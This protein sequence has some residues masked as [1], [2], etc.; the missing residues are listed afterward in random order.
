MIVEEEKEIDAEGWRF[1]GTGCPYSRWRFVL[2]SPLRNIHEYRTKL[3]SQDLQRRWKSVFPS[4]SPAKN[5]K[6]AKKK[7]GALVV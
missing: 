6:S 4:P 2:F 5:A 3:H 1:N 7:A